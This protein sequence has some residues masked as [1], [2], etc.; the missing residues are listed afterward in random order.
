MTMGA[1][2]GWERTTA[3]RIARMPGSMSPREMNRREVGLAAIG[4]CLLAIAMTWPL[5]LHLGDTVPRD[6]GDP[7]AEAWQ[8]A[9][10]GHALLHQPLHFCDANR[11]WPTKYSLAFGDALIG[12]APSGIIGSGPHAAMVR[13]DALFIFAYALAF[14]G[15]YLLA[16]ELGLGPLGAVIAGAAFAFAP[17]RLEQEGH[18]QGISSGGVPLV[19]RLAERRD[20]LGDR[21]RGARDPAAKTLVDLLCLDR[22]CLAALDRLGARPSV[23]LRDRLRRADRRDRLAPPR[24]AADSAADDRRRG[25]GRHR[26]P[27][28]LVLDRARLPLHRGPLP[29]VEAKRGRGRGLLGTAQG[30]PDGAGG[31]LRLGSRHGGHPR[32]AHH[33]AGENP[34]PGGGDP[35][36]GGRRPLVEQ[37]EQALADRA[38]DRRTGVRDPVAR[39][40]L[41]GRTAL[42][43]SGPLRGASRLERNPHPGPYGDLHLP[44][45]RPARRRR[46]RGRNQSGAA[47]AIARLD[48]RDRRRGARPRDRHR[49]PQ[50]PVRP[51]RQP[52][53]ARGAHAACL[54][55]RHPAAAAP[56][57]GAHRQGEPRLPAGVHRRLPR[58]GQRP[59]KHQPGHRA[60]PR[61]AHGDLP[62]RGDGQG[63]AGVRRPHGDPP[64]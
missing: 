53:G 59:S 38:W 16:R 6:I 1:A 11:F 28:L 61:Q 56:P 58:D 12:Y 18:L 37:P 43:L 29:G 47:P 34:L 10:G 57:A 35:D 52:G 23:R 44:G 9:W 62:G 63:A 22:G 5:L 25:G 20:S 14:F 31:E 51:L 4:A 2:Y 50:H 19:A 13:Y 27:A 49:G 26:L 21:L 45:P 60:G 42:A 15:A 36:P 3:S 39:L 32:H 33:L 8:P 40:P 30:L 64:P 55:L 54:H 41:G 24:A 17:Y 48:R 7:L 46:S